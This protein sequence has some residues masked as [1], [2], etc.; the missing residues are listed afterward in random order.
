[1]LEANDAV[2][3]ATVRTDE[4]ALGFIDSAI[5]LARRNLNSREA[6]RLLAVLAAEASAPEHAA[7]DW[8]TQRYDRIRATITEA[9]D[10]DIAAGRLPA[11]IHAADVAPQIIGLWDGLQLQWLI[12]PGFDMIPALRRGLTT[13]LHTE[14][15]GHSGQ[16]PA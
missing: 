16:R 11:G 4:T 14:S 12:D 7:H 10:D 2:Q 8:F 6:V 5:A 3:L 15:N 1:V 13:L 9:V